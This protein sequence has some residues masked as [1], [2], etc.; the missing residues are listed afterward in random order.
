V[1]VGPVE[2]A[3]PVEYALVVPP[4]LVVLARYNPK[5]PNVLD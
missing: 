2:M 5:K 3:E 1:I 4:A